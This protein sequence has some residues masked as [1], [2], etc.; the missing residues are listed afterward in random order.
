MCVN[1]DKSVQVFL[2]WWNKLIACM[3]VTLSDAD[4]FAVKE[5]TVSWLLLKKKFKF[6]HEKYFLSK[7]YAILKKYYPYYISPLVQNWETCY[8]NYNRQF[9]S[10][11]EDLTGFLIVYIIFWPVFF[12]VGFL[13]IT[14]S[15]FTGLLVKRRWY[16]EEQ[17]KN[18]T[19]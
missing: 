6:T 1:S 4:V 11:C 3:H 10:Y 15:D 16:T 8:T 9:S 17:W 14:V 5:K 2:L 19:L 18:N 12:P 7:P 13:Y